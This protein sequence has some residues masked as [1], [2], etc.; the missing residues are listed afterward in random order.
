M[1]SALGSGAELLPRVFDV[2]RASAA[3]VVM[4]NDASTPAIDEQVSEIAADLEQSVQ[5]TTK[6]VRRASRSFTDELHLTRPAATFRAEGPFTLTYFDVRGQAEKIRLAFVLA[7]IEFRDDRISFSDWADR[8]P[9]TRYGQLPCL[10]VGGDEVCQSG[11]I[12][13]SAAPAPCISSVRDRRRLLRRYVALAEGK[14]LYPVADPAKCVQIEEVLGLLDDLRAAWQPCVDVAS[15]PEAYGYKADLSSEQKDV[16]A[17]RLRTRFLA[18]TLPRFL[19]FFTTHIEAHGGFFLN[20][21]EPTIADCT[22]LPQFQYFA[23]GVADHVPA[24]CLEP[25]PTI[26]DYVDRMMNIPAVR[27]YYAKTASIKAYRES[28]SNSN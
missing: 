13:K 23:S 6:A 27:A 5:E 14:T 28:R 19:G 20:G 9:K 26:T 7:N 2:P 16:L 24:D 1:L 18:E 15:K 8:K 11:A 21:D 10:T 25:F 3:R 4:G 12:L 17:K 22:A